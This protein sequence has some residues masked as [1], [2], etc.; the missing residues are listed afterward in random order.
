LLVGL[1]A[2]GGARHAY[3]ACFELLW[4]VVMLARSSQT[5][6]RDDH[7]TGNCVANMACIFSGSQVKIAV[8]PSIPYILLSMILSR[9][10]FARR[11]TH[12][13]LNRMIRPET[14]RNYV[15][16]YVFARIGRASANNKYI[17]HKVRLNLQ[18]VVGWV[19]L[20]QP[21]QLLPPVRPRPRSVVWVLASI[22]FCESTEAFAREKG[23]G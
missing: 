17:R 22:P 18:Q 4:R 13:L 9:A 20:H 12:R 19:P 3:W 1:M 10:C 2:C 16:E 8:V 5:L 23:A 15:V 21:P 14:R 7:L 6:D 11:K